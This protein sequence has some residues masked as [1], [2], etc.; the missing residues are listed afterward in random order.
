[1]TGVQTCALPILTTYPAANKKVTEVP[2]YKKFLEENPVAAVLLAQSEHAAI[3]PVDPTGGKILDEL[4]IAAEKIEIEGVSAQE[5]LDEAQ[6]NAQ[7]ALD[8]ALEN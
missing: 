5:A 2:E 8:E 1:M 3:Y 6:A 4:N 7:I